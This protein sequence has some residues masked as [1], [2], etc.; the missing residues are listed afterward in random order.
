MKFADARET[1]LEHFGIGL[2]GD[3]RD[4]LGCQAVEETVHD[5]A[6]APEI[7][8]GPAAAFGQSRHAA[9]EAMAV[10]VAKAWQR[11]AVAL[12]PGFRHGSGLDRGDPAVGDAQP[13]VLFPAITDP[14]AFEPER[15]SEER[16]VGKECVSTCRSRWSPYH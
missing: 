16:S 5:L 11:D 4:I 3:R 13:H 7:V 2:R 9:L 14:R 15:R 12:V 6:P 10:D 1:R 8:I